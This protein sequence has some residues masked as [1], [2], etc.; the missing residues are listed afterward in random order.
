MRGPLR[1]IWFAVGV[2]ADS[3]PQLSRLRE[4]QGPSSDVYYYRALAW[5]KQW[6]ESGRITGRLWEDLARAIRWPAEPVE[7]ERVFL[8]CGIVSADGRLWG[9]W[10]WNGRILAQM[11]HDREYHRKKY[12]E[13]KGKKRVSSAKKA[14]K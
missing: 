7:L 12:K 1:G 11:E 2:Q 5:F 3:S 14:K 13:K 10:E 4:S 8:Q 9:W 6:A